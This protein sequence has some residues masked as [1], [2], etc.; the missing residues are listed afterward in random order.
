MSSATLS[1][2]KTFPMDALMRATVAPAAGR[3]HIAGN[4]NTRR[5]GDQRCAP[6]RCDRGRR[7]ARPSTCRDRRHHAGRRGYPSDLTDSQWERLQPLLCD[8]SCTIRSRP[9][10]VRAVLDAI[11]YRW[12]SGCTWRML[13]HD[14]P[15][16]KTVYGYFRR[17]RRQGVLPQIRSHLTAKQDDRETSRRGRLSIQTTSS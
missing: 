17:W 15:P 10:D 6:F 12:H 16:W 9:T 3:W 13:P 1:L 8:E 11:N 4:P 7:P 2:D 5:E 14:F